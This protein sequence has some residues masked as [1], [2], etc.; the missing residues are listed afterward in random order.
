MNAPLF[1]VLT[2]ELETPD[3]ATDTVTGSKRYACERARQ[4]ARGKQI[5]VRVVSCYGDPIDY[6]TT[7][8]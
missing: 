8:A 4:L 7:Y 1:D 3:W 6:F 2:K 5:L